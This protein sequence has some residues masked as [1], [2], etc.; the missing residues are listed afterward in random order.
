MAPSMTHAALQLSR[1]GFDLKPPSPDQLKALSATLDDEESRVILNHGTEAA[2]CG[3]FTDNKQ[4]G[5]YVCRL[6]G[7]P[8]FRSDKKF[9]SG[10]GWPS[11][12]DPIDRHHVAF[13]RDQSYGMERTEIRCA[14]C[15]GHLG[16]VF[17][18]GPPPT[19]SR[20]C[21]NSVSLSFVKSGENLP[22][23]LGRGSPEGKPLAGAPIRSST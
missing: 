16:H 14:R 2:F 13:I 11:F 19:Y 7:L 6:C 8:L 4:A 12:F 1:A 10:T 23:L 15:Q 9:D 5:T 20:Y 17:P 3:I 21:L 18:D 22:D